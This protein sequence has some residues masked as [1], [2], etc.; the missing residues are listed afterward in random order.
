MKDAADMWIHESFTN[1]SENLFVDYHF[2]K[3]EAEDYVIGCRKLIAND[4]PIIG[5]YGLNQTGSGGDMYYKGGNILHTFH[6]SK[7]YST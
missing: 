5:E 1:Y 4:I 3:K 2:S 7:Y 6:G